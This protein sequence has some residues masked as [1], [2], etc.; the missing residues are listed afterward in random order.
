MQL[1]PAIDIYGG[2][3]V[4]L[5]RGDYNQMTVY[6]T[7]PVDV[8]HTFEQ[9]GASCIHMVDLEGARTGQTPNLDAICAVAAQTGLFCEVGG[10]VRSMDVVRAYLD[11]GVDRVI[12]GTAAVQDPAFLREAVRAYGNRIAVGIDLKDGQVATH[13]WTQ[14][15]ALSLDAFLWGLQDA[16]VQTIICT[17]ISKDG[18]LQGCNVELYERLARACSMDI[19]ASGGVSTIEDIRAL[20]R[21]DIA[22]AIIGKAYYEGKLDLVQA[23]AAAAEEQGIQAEHHASAA[24]DSGDEAG[25]ATAC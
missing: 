13:G 4:R 5:T 9:S 21:L 11:G 6:G 19:I 12:I 25:E 2:K 8:A 15:E 20:A 14:T 22:G 7:S 18:V 17:D 16:G 24:P 10:G 3:V 23:L 1:Y